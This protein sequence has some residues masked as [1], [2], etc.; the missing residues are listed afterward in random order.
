M[1]VLIKLISLQHILRNIIAAAAIE[2]SGP[3]KSLTPKGLNYTIYKSIA[4]ECRNGKVVNDAMEVQTRRI[5][6]LRVLTE[7]GGAK[8]RRSN[9]FCSKEL[10][11]KPAQEV[12][13][14]NAN[15]G[16]GAY[17]CEM[18]IIKGKRKEEIT[19][20]LR[21]HIQLLADATLVLRATRS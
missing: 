18:L 16:R 17:I 15:I 21:G 10:I 11:I 12:T 7:L 2:P 5:A 4:I 8:I 3:R 20:T 6:S 13:E 9:L 1:K 14:N 19:N